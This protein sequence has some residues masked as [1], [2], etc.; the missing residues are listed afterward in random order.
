MIGRLLHRLLG[1]RRAQ[2]RA[3]E[4]WHAEKAKRLEYLRTLD[5]EEPF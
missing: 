1:R 2:R 4:Q 5:Q 3:W